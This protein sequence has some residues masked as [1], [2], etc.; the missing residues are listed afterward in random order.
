VPLTAQHVRS[1]LG[2]KVSTRGQKYFLNNHVLDI[3]TL[4]E[5]PDSMHVFATVKGTLSSPY[6]CPVGK[7]CKHVAA[8]C[9][10]MIANSYLGNKKPARSEGFKWL[11]SIQKSTQAVTQNTLPKDFFLHYYFTQQHL[12]EDFHIKKHKFLKNGKFSAGTA[13]NINSFLDEYDHKVND[14]KL[15]ID[16][17][18]SDLLRSLVDRY[19]HRELIIKGRVGYYLLKALTQTGR[20]FIN[21]TTHPLRLN[22]EPLQL[23]FD[24]KDHSNNQLKL[25]TNL[26]KAHSF[27][28]TDPPVFIDTNNHMVTEIITDL[29][30]EILIRLM[31]SPPIKKSE[32]GQIYQQLI[33]SKNFAQ[34][35]T[36][37]SVKTNKILTQPVPCLTI[38]K[39]I[40]R[41]FGS[42]QNRYS[43]LMTFKYDVHRIDVHDKQ[44]VVTIYHAN[45]FHNIHRDFMLER[46]A[47][48][49][50]KS[51]GFVGTE[52]RHK[53][54][55][56][57]PDEFTQQQ[58]LTHWNQFINQ[59]I[60]TLEA[61]GWVIESQPELQL[62]IDDNAQIQIKSEHENN[63][64][65]LAFDIEINGKPRP[66]VPL[67][68]GLLADIDH[69]D[70][71]PDKYFLTV[72]DDQYVSINTQEVKPILNTLIELY[73]R[74]D[75]TQLKISAFDAHLID[76]QLDEM[77]GDNNQL[78]WQG[79]KEILELSKKIKNYKGIESI[80]PPQALQAQLRDYQQKG[81]DWLG[82]L[83]HFKF[84]GILA[85]DMGLGK[86]IQTLAHLSKLKEQKQLVGP[87][88]II[89]P[90]SLITNWKIEIEKFTPNLSTLIF[91]GSDRFNLLKKIKKTDLIITTYTLVVRDHEIHKPQQYSH[92][93]LDEAQKIK[94]P[95]TKMAKT[96]C[97]LKAEYKIALSG[98]PIE[99]HLGEL[100][101]I[102]NFLM[103]GFL[104][105]LAQFKS[106]YQ[107]PIEKEQDSYKQEL[108]NKR[109]QPFILRRKKESVLD[110]LPAKTEIIKRTQFSAPQAKLYESIRLSMEKK[111][112]DAIAGQG[113]NKS[114][115]TI[116]DA[117]LKLRQVCCDPSLVKLKQA[118]ELKESAKLELFLELLD[119]LLEGQ[120]KI[121]VFSQFTSML[122]ILEQA[123]KAK[124]ISYV[125]LTG[126]STKR[127]KIIERFSKG[128]AE[129]FLISLKAGGVGLNLVEADTVIHY[130]PWWNPAVE[131]QATDRAHRIGQDKANFQVK[132]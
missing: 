58:L 22:P 74:N 130:D 107:N 71:L 91:Y 123:I 47:Q 1:N 16:H 64:F 87:S 105:N 40:N 38:N 57:S 127:E 92:L 116:L 69:I 132:I 118:Q 29:D 126:A 67:I 114:H 19:F 26:P 106:F 65:S 115:I 25:T 97:S 28:N 81:L 78:M 113:L 50:I 109:I 124:D 62:N 82:F 129:V 128:E 77:L 6:H 61:A 32:A 53:L 90:T 54:H 89:V 56:K 21:D 36:P 99:N 43:L 35:P 60:P 119:E 49:M 2:T 48:S 7:D 122:K 41:A 102:F 15:K 125:K 5:G 70:D 8:A 108:L 93:I 46:A 76:D 20:F 84:G 17:E 4:E 79:N 55:L 75:Q 98:T 27:F 42:T 88:L 100:W 23:S 18:I 95:R 120:H 73:D 103:P 63:W 72:E 33:Q 34:L 13:I 94:N 45:Q 30:N 110:E 31:E 66:L 59:H 52:Q 111:V 85:D 131:N 112:R 37:P 24:W 104:K 96:I 83:H 121:L 3:E 14:Y 101:S 44:Q 51:F 12:Y 68:S 117:L 11:E 39:D 10:F 9:F 86:T 80:Q